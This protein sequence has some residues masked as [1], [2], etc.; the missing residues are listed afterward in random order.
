M[1]KSII[2]R[3]NE[4]NPILNNGHRVIENNKQNFY[5]FED[6]VC[7]KDDGTDVCYKTFMSG[8]P[9]DLPSLNIGSE[10]LKCHGRVFALSQTLESIIRINYDGVVDAEARVDNS[11]CS[12]VDVK[13]NG[14]YVYGLFE[15]KTC[16]RPFIQKYNEILVVKAS[17]YPDY[18]SNI[19]IQQLK[20]RWS[21]V[22]G[23]V[24]AITQVID[25]DGNGDGNGHSSGQKITFF[26]ENAVL[27][28]ITEVSNGDG[29]YQF[30]HDDNIYILSS[31]YAILSYEN[32]FMIINLIT[33]NIV[34]YYETTTRP[35]VTITND[36]DFIVAIDVRAVYCRIPL[37]HNTFPIA[38]ANNN[39]DMNRVRKRIRHNDVFNGGL[40]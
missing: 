28:E 14:S 20:H 23:D 31:N 22:D 4:G 33:E 36:Y 8:K 13:T 37:R 18:I 11:I 17:I 15:D 29:K 24:F 12:C 35:N 21:V 16:G 5:V 38:D 32:G 19:P 26:T 7:R 25:G 2:E 30:K 6:N 40:F 9:M 34:E 27:K 1:S 3:H 10:P 39:Y